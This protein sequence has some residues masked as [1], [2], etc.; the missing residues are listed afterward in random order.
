MTSANS[1]DETTILGERVK[2]NASSE[3]DPKFSV[4]T[5]KN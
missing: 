1:S 4:G 3:K 5:V 2:E